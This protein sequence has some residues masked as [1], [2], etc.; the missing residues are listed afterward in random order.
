L[1]EQGPWL[2]AGATLSSSDDPR[3]VWF[4]GRNASL[5]LLQPQRAADMAV[6]RGR[7][8]CLASA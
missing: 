6:R 3:V 2:P 8:G 4:C 5:A 1:G 7:P